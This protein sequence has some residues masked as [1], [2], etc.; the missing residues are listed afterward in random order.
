MATYYHYLGSDWPKWGDMRFGDQLTLGSEDANC[1]QG[2]TYK[3]MS[4]SACGS[5]NDWGT[6]QMEVWYRG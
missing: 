4:N 2:S 3:G 1:Q 5:F 6:T